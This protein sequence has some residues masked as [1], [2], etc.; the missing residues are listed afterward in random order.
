MDFL[1]G[2]TSPKTLVDS[3]GDGVVTVAECPVKI[4]GNLASVAQTLANQAQANLEDVKRRTP[5]DP[6]V[7]IDAPVKAVAQTFKAG[8]SLVGAF[9]NP[10]AATLSEVQS[11][12]QRVTG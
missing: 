11:Q 6:M 1:K 4:A 10:L 2:L 5:D 9:V 7:L 3:I 12:I 8:V